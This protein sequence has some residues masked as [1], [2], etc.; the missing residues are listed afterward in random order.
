M[1]S[2]HMPT[3][4]DSP[5]GRYSCPQCLRVNSITI[6]VRF[7]S[8]VCL[9]RAGLA[10]VGCHD[11]V[12]CFV[13]VSDFVLFMAHYAYYVNFVNIFAASLGHSGHTLCIKLFLTRF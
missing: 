8:A 9:S 7:V 5:F 11:L 2:V 1:Q 4:Q 6:A 10:I 3:G 12:L 13:L